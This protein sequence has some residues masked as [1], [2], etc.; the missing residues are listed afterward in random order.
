MAV[1]YNSNDAY[2]GSVRITSKE[3]L[4]KLSVIK[5][6]KNVGIGHEEIFCQ[7]SLLFCEPKKAA[8]DVLPIN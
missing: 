2:Y 1:I 5:S 7:K 8:I 6:G 3:T 4:F